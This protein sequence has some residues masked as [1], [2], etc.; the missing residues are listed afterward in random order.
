MKAKRSIPRKLRHSPVGAAVAAAL[1]AAVVALPA[2]AG[3]VATPEGSTS[4]T[5]S[6]PE[7]I[8]VASGFAVGAAAGGPIGALVGAAAGGW[9]GDRMHREQ[10]GHARTRDALAVANQRGAGL[11]VTVMFRTD[12]ASVRAEDESLLAQF[13][14]LAA[15]TPGATV[16]VTGFADPRG[17][18]RH[19]AALAAERASTVATRLVAAGLPAD[20]L[21]V[22]SDVAPSPVPA[23]GG[24]SAADLDGYALQRRVVVR[25]QPANP[26]AAAALAQRH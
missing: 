5:A 21:V 6:R 16:Q 14:A 13:A 26:G 3:T 15:A 23:D 25:I 19:N 1:L 2:S 20:R 12:D 7:S 22:S 10:A 9:L 24:V 18:A 11:T 17:S 4:S 8:G